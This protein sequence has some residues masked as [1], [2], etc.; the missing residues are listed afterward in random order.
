[1]K[2]LKIR[3]AT[4]KDADVLVEFR[5]RMFRDMEPEKNFSKSR[6]QF[7]RKS[8]EYYS[9]YLGTKGQYDCLALVDGRL[10]GCGSV[11]F[12]VRP[13]HI[14][15]LENTMGY[16]LNVYVEKEYRGRGDSHLIA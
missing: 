1:M 6:A 11:L 2:Q 13:P 14:N 4:K 5:Y 12:W 9:K 8:R 3:K 7:I 16:I 10:V 15:H